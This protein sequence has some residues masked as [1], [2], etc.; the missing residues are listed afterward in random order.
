MH[1]GRMVQAQM[2]VFN[3][4]RGI[5]VDASGNIY[6]AD[7]Y[8]NRIRKITPSGEVTTLAGSS[9]GY[10]DGSGA[11]ARRFRIHPDVAVDLLGNVYVADSYNHRIRK[12]NSMGIVTTIAGSGSGGFT[13]GLGTSA[14]FNRPSGIAIDASGIIYV[15]DRYNHRIRTVSASGQV[16][17]ISRE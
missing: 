2:Q 8:N 15:A 11:E 3:E 6:V 7:F 10:Q 4:P 16:T 12:I 13:D 9:Y 5:D 1:L 17:T 14:R